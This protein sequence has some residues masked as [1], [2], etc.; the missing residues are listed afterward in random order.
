MHTFPQPTFLPIHRNLFVQLGGNVG[1]IFIMW[2]FSLDHTYTN[3]KRYVQCFFPKNFRCS[4]TFWMQ[5]KLKEN[6]II[7]VWHLY[8]RYESERFLRISVYY[9]YALKTT[10]FTTIP[11]REVYRKMLFQRKNMAFIRTQVWRNVLMY[12]FGWI[13]SSKKIGATDSV[14]PFETFK[15]SF[16]HYICLF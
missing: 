7:F 10:Q 14:T 12:G 15:I 1:W 11:S 4:T 13:S 5:A 16:S 8:T 2:R 9:N 6:C 3:Q